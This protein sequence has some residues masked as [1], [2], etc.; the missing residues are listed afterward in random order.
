M[1]WDWFREVRSLQVFNCAAAEI[2]VAHYQGAIF[3]HKR[4]ASP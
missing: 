2:T 4:A 1:L 3:P